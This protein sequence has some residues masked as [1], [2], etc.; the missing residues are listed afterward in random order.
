VEGVLE[1]EAVALNAGFF[2]RIRENRPLVTLKI[3][4]SADGRTTSA[5]GESRWVTGEEARQLGH[6]LRARH[7]AI[8]IGVETALADNPS[9]TCRL[10]G[11]E[12]RSPVRVVLDSRLRLPPSSKLVQT[13][14]DTPTWVFTV[15]EGGAELHASGV[16]VFVVGKDA[17]GRPDI[18]TVLHALAERGMTR[19]LVE[20]GAGV[21]AS[22]IDRG[23]A[24]RLEIFQAPRIFGAAGQP[25]VAALAALGL[26]EV[27]R[28]NRVGIRQTG[29]DL[30][31]SF[32]ATH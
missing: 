25:A 6:L 2:L 14:K 18:A 24:D 16:E 15:T 23:L 19:L 26:D 17:R 32:N 7:D 22:F 8:A 5:S 27:P 29:C 28:F 1:S 4:A 11:L 30:L 21:H 10:P 20:G 9:L 12:D 13:A 31:E 3:A